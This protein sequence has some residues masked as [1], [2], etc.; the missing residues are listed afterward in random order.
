MT[1]HQS[2]GLEFH[3]VVVGATVEDLLPHRKN[4]EEGGERAIHPGRNALGVGGDDAREK[5]NFLTDGRDLRKTRHAFLA[6]HQGTDGR[7]MRTRTRVLIGVA[8]VELIIATGLLT[9]AYRPMQRE[10]AAMRIGA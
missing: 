8:L 10:R 9:V 3:T 4:V 6:L 7:T 5:Q 1:I 2:K